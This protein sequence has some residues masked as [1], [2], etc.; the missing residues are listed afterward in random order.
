MTQE[1]GTVS[2]ELTDLVGMNLRV[3]QHFLTTSSQVISPFQ[4]RLLWVMITEPPFQN[5]FERFFF[6]PL[7]VKTGDFML[8]CFTL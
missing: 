5:I 7:N 2:R 3:G 4:E 6:L 8:A 1:V